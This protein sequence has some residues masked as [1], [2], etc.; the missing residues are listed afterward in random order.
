MRLLGIAGLA[1]LGV[2]AAGCGQPATTDTPRIEEKIFRITS[3]TPPVRFSF[4]TGEL[5]DVRVTER[6]NADTGE[7]TYGPV[8]KATLKVRNGAEDESA[9]LVGGELTYI[10][11]QGRPIKLADGRGDTGFTFGSYGDERLDPGANVSKDIDVPFPV[12]A[13]KGETLGELRL[14][15]RYV[16]LPYRESTARIPASVA[17]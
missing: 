16:A 3:E 7:V 13:L 2:I 12:A 14:R 1:G 9:R 5:S 6:V 15:L 10:D 11:V 17:R 8:L 4:L